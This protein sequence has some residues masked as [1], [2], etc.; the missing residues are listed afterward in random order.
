[1]GLG[2]FLIYSRVPK[3]SCHFTPTPTPTLTLEMTSQTTLPHFIFIRLIIIFKLRLLIYFFKILK[4]KYKNAL[5]KNIN[6]IARSCLE[7]PKQKKTL[8]YTL[9]SIRP[10][11]FLTT[12]HLRISQRDTQRKF[13]IFENP[14]RRNSHYSKRDKKKFQFN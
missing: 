8:Q 12:Y 7:S 4:I 9:K 3:N 14:Q 6:S 10:P 5:K 11:K 1:M 13:H 2:F